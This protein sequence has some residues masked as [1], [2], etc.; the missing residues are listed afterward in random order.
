MLEFRVFDTGI[1]I[2]HKDIDRIFNDF[3]TID[4][5]YTRSVEGVGLGLGI[6]R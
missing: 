1:G 2:H 5:A 6:V 4:S 3:E